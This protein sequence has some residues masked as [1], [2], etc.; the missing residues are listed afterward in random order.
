MV[1]GDPAAFAAMAGRWF[2]FDTTF[3]RW[4]LFDL[5]FLGAT[6]DDDENDDDDDGTNANDTSAGNSNA[7]AIITNMM[8]KDGEP[9]MIQWPLLFVQLGRLQTANI[10]EVKQ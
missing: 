7:T 9:M 5:Q 3:C 6:H 2:A 8:V 10:V 1:L 4:L